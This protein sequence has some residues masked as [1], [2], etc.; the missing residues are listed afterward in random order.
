MGQAG[1]F[2]HLFLGLI[3]TIVLILLTAFFLRKTRLMQ[4]GQS[5]FASVKGVT[6][7]SL[8]EKIVVVESGG[9]WLL[10]GVT[11]NQITTLHKFDDIPDSFL[12]NQETYFEEI[13]RHFL[14]KNK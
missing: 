13:R 3:S 4:A 14:N 8:K 2:F 1:S 6:S 11:P 9:Q 12:K 5:H 7:I 10:L